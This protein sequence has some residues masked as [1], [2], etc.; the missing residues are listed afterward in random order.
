MEVRQFV[1]NTVV[2]NVLMHG[3]FRVSLQKLHR[4]FITSRI[5]LS[6][7]CESVSVKC[8]VSFVIRQYLQKYSAQL[9][10]SVNPPIMWKQRLSPIMHATVPVYIFPSKDMPFASSSHKS[11]TSLL[12]TLSTPK[13]IYSL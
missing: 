10:F 9:K 1:Q 7:N 8:T 2:F 5:S 12:K 4:L 6:D 11:V 13:N 3:H